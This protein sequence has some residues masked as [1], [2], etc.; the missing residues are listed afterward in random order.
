M[1]AH[2]DITGDK[3]ISG[4]ASDAYR[5]GYDRIFGSKKK[6]VDGAAIAS[7]IADAIVSVQP[8]DEAGKALAQIHEFLANNPNET[9]GIELSKVSN[10]PT[11][12]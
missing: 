9:F 8:M 7:A 4:E 2:N 1:T 5:T 3:I 10:D 12:F 11:L 6:S